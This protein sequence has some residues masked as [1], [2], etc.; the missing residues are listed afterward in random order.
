[1][2]FSWHV[3][4]AN[5]VAAQAAASSNNDAQEAYEARESLKQERLKSAALEEENKALRGQVA[6]VLSYL[7][8]VMP[9]DAD[10]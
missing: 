1:L 6:T 2:L 7:D 10:Q 9:M 3:L 5:Q 8:Q 4:R